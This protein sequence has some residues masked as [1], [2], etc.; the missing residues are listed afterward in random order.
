MKKKHIKWNIIELQY[1]EQLALQYYSKA[2]ESFFS[3]DFVATSN[4]CE[5]YLLLSDLTSELCFFYTIVLY[6]NTQYSKAIEIS[7]KIY[8]AIFRLHRFKVYTSA[9]PI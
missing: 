2:R 5:Q 8:A 4:F 3:M 1:K 7:E 9:V 6:H